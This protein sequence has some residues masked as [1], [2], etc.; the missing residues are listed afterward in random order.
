MIP[1]SYLASNEEKMPALEKYREDRTLENKGLDAKQSL[2][3]RKLIYDYYKNVEFTVSN[4]TK[5]MTCMKS[6]NTADP[7]GFSNPFLK[8]LQFSLARP[9]SALYSY[10]FMWKDSK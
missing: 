1:T 9:L 6:S 8:R 10:I 5:V 7:Q 4:I 2:L 3:V